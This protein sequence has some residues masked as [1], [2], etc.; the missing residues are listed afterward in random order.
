MGSIV[1]RMLNTQLADRVL[2]FDGESAYDPASLLRVVRSQA[3]RYVTAPSAIVDQYNKNVSKAQEISVKAE[4]KPLSRDWTIPQEYA[5]LN[6][7]DYM[8]QAHSLLFDELPAS[9]FA[10]RERRLAEELVIYQRK[11]LDDVLRTIIWIINI[12]TT[13]NVV[14]GVGR[15]S[16]VSSYVLYVI[17]VHDVDSHAYALDIDDFLRD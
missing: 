13:N 1:A 6:V 3:V 12:L 5:N 14:W 16:S 9:E 2:W 11:G 7:I 10:E 15:G 4:C 8:F 17:G